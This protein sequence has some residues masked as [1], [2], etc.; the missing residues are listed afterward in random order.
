MIAPQRGHP[1]P[2]ATVSDSAQLT[3]EQAIAQK[4]RRRAVPP[5]LVVSRDLIG[6]FV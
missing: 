2:E 5:A 6:P 4:E 1:L 3:L